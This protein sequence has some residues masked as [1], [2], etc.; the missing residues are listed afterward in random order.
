MYSIRSKT[1]LL[2][3]KSIQIHSFPKNFELSAFPFSLGYK[4]ISKSLNFPGLRVH[5]AKYEHTDIKP[6][7]LKHYSMYNSNFPN[8]REL[9]KAICTT[10]L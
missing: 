6:V 9:Q 1:M 5:N 4:K 8:S 2:K 10:R 3:M 7:C